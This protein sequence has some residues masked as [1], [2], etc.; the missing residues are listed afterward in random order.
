[1]NEKKLGVLV[2]LKNK[3]IY[4]LLTDGDLRRELKRDE[5]PIN[6][7]KYM[8]KSPYVVNV[9][10]PESKVLEK[11]NEKKITSL[12]VVSDKDLNKRNKKIVGII[13]IH[14]L[15]KKGF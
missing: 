6:F 14:S 13:H 11:M 12:L 8:T 1:M 7:K 10:M 2:I 15:L 9:N 4:G 5:N 3:F